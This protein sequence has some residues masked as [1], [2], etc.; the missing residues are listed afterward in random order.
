M[1]RSLL[2]RTL[3]AAALGMGVTAGLVRAEEPPVAAG[4][5]VGTEG[6]MPANAVSGDG[7]GSVP[8]APKKRLVECLRPCNLLHPLRNHRPLGCYANFN[9]FSCTNLSTELLWVFGSCRQYFG[10]R[11]PQGATAVARPRFQPAHPDLCA[12]RQRASH[13]RPAA[14]QLPLKICSPR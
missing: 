1:I 5:V 9:D 10:E 8:C 13:H 12:A 6:A 11:L 14:L 2:R 3:L 7:Q 4:P